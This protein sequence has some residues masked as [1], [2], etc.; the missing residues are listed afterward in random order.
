MRDCEDRDLKHLQ[1]LPLEE[2]IKLSKMRLIEF[3]SH[4]GGKVYISFSG[5]KDSTALLHL[6]RSI[7][8]EVVGV[9]CDTGLEFPEIKEFVRSQ[10]NIITIRPKVGFKQVIEKYGWPIISKEQSM[11]I[12]RYRNAKSEKHKLYRLNGDGHRKSGVISKKWGYLIHAP[13]KISERCCDVMKKQPFKKYQMESG[14][15]PIIGTMASESNLRRRQWEKEGC[16]IFEG[17][18]TSSKPLSFWTEKDIY[19]YLE[20]F[21]IKI[22]DIYYKGAKRTGCIFCLYGH[23]NED[24]NTN[25]LTLLKDNHPKLY[26]YCMNTLGMNQVLDWYPKKR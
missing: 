6:V 23:H 18:R 25:R 9:F 4:V 15:F 22:S 12:N 3:Y 5:G 7:Y 13:F 14:L 1:N 2:K 20:K 26:E 11:A 21:N 16:N 8:P 19:S 17:D 10:E 24:S